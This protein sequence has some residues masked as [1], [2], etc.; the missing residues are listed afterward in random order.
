[1]WG[2]CLFLLVIVES[3]HLKI[4]NSKNHPSPVHQF[5]KYIKIHPSLGFRNPK[6]GSYEMGAGAKGDN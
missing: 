2:S 5:L 1:M 4:K 3:R 6:R